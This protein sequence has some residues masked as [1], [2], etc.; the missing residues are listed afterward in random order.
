MPTLPAGTRAPDALPTNPASEGQP[1]LMAPANATVS[2]EQQ[3]QYRNP[4]TLILDVETG[5]LTV[6]SIEVNGLVLWTDAGGAP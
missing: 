4:R 1:P 3:Y 6:V 2:L 5:S